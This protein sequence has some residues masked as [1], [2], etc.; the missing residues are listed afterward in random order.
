MV[1]VARRIAGCLHGGTDGA[2]RTSRETHANSHSGAHGD[3]DSYTCGH[4]DPRA[5]GAGDL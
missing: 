4:A 3:S 5:Y 2:A 1:P